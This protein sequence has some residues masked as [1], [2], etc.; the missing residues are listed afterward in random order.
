MDLVWSPLCTVYSIFRRLRMPW[1]LN[2]VRELQLVPVSVLCHAFH[3]SVG[4]LICVFFLSCDIISLWLAYFTQNTYN[5]RRKPKYRPH[6]L[7]GH[8][9]GMKNHG[10]S[11]VYMFH[12]IVGKLL[13]LLQVLWVSHQTFRGDRGQ[14]E[15]P[16]PFLGWLSL[17]VLLHWP[18]IC[19]P[20]LSGSSFVLFVT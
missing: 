18:F 10:E 5:L 9:P 13:G 8:I 3:I 11:C 20:L 17:R 6:I 7:C 15:G 16:A 14:G 1:C 2:A 12:F 19:W 4:L